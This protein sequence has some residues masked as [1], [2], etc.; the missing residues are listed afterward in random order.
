MADQL[1]LM[2]RIPEEEEW[3]LHN[4]DNNNGQGTSYQDSDHTYHSF[5]I[6][7]LYC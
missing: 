1:C 6:V 5:E 2:T 4:S 7:L 3:L